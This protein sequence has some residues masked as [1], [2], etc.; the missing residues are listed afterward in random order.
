MCQFWTIYQIAVFSAN[1]VSNMGCE[2]SKI[3]LPFG[4]KIDCNF[5]YVIS[6]CTNLIYFL[7]DAQ[8]HDIFIRLMFKCESRD[9]IDL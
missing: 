2:Q 7:E 9:C 4:L 1:L 5:I 3:Q 8:C 6:D